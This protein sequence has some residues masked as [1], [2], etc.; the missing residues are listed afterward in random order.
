MS[1]KLV[2]IRQW[3]EIQ[4]LRGDDLT[5]SELVLEVAYIF[6]ENFNDDISADELRELRKQYA[7]VFNE[8]E[9]TYNTP[10]IEL[11]RIKVNTFIDLDLYLTKFTLKDKIEQVA[12]L[13]FTDMDIQ[14]IPV[15][16]IMGAIKNFVAWREEIIDKYKGFFNV[17]Q[18]E[19]DYEDE[20]LIE[21][22]EDDELIE[23]PEEKW[24]WLAVV[25]NLASGDITKVDAIMDKTLI[26]V[27]NWAS[28]RK[29]F[30]SRQPKKIGQNHY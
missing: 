26:S 10:H 12:S 24:G 9:A 25:Y 11:K 28:M 8:I 4:E 30:E 16:D 20:D 21:D 17:A 6:D 23:T 22:D 14:T 19:D 13:L 5:A 18:N 7:F 27:L 29:D 15:S 3:I 1:S 2:N